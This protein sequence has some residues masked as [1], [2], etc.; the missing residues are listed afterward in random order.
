MGKFT[1]KKTVFFKNP[2]FYENGSQKCKNK[3]AHSAIKLQGRN[4]YVFLQTVCELIK[5]TVTIQHL[6]IINFSDLNYIIKFI[7]SRFQI[8]TYIFH[9]P[10]NS[11]DRNVF[12]PLVFRYLDL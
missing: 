2:I 5:N 7:F 6:L 3:W 12:M 11:L 9:E 10:R 4:N 1:Y 8:V